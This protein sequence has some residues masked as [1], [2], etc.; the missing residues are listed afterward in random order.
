MKQINVDANVDEFNS[1]LCSTILKAAKQ[2]VRKR[3]RNFKRKMVPW[4]SVECI[5]AISDRNK[6]LKVFKRYVC[7]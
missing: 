4:W 6:A 1:S 3:E 2:T 5:N 7:F